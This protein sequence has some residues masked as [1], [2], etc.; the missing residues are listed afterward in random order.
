[1]SPERTTEQVEINVARAYSK[2]MSSNSSLYT[3]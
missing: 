2:L 1:M 3:C